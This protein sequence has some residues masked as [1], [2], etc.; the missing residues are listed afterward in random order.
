MR[1][2][3][4]TTNILTGCPCKFILLS[5]TRAMP[6]ARSTMSTPAGCCCFVFPTTH[7]QPSIG[8]HA[9]P[10][11][12]HELTDYVGVRGPRPPTAHCRAV[13]RNKA[14]GWLSD[15]WATRPVQIQ[16]PCPSDR[17]RTLLD[18]AH[19]TLSDT[20]LARIVAQGTAPNTRPPRQLPDPEDYFL[21]IGSTHIHHNSHY[22]RRL[23][24]PINCRTSCCLSVI[25]RC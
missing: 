4:F 24:V 22:P 9:R 11:Q 5:T 15:C 14:D 10:A 23:H 18:W 6:M 1:N 19:G 25:S 8:L 7:S 13:L 17:R 2:G 21:G 3:S 16:L 12:D 20:H